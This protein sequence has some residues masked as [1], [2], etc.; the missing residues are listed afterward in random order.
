MIVNDRQLQPPV[1]APLAEGTFR[2]LTHEE[3]TAVSGGGFWAEFGA[4]VG[5]SVDY[6]WYP[7]TGT[8]PR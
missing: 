5:I 4:A 6:I 7:L 2:E 8:A 3:T 1:A